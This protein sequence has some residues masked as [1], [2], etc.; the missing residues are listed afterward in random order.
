MDKNL[1][2][3]NCC[4][5]SLAMISQVCGLSTFIFGINNMKWETEKWGR[6][7]NWREGRKVN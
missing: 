1:A 3:M 4:L 7:S 2:L 5:I 6:G